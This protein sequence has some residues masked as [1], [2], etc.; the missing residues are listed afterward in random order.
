MGA[1]LHEADEQERRAELIAVAI[2]L[3]IAGLALIGYSCLV[4]SAPDE[5]QRKQEDEDQME[6][7]KKWREKHES[8]TD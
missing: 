7:L 3:I 5:E 2:I 8:K 6:Y 1:D 4:A